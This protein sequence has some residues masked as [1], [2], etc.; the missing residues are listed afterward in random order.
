MMTVMNLTAGTARRLNCAELRRRQFGDIRNPPRPLPIGRNRVT[1]PAQEAEGAVRV[2]KWI[3]IEI[4][5]IAASGL[6]NPA[7]GTLLMEPVG[8]HGAERAYKCTFWFWRR[9]RAERGKPRCPAIWQ[10]RRSALASAQLR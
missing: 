5:A 3:C 2:V 6:N 1:V 10:W 9:K 4:A 7:S 8:A